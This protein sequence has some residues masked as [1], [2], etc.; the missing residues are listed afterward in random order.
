MFEVQVTLVINNLCPILLCKLFQ[1]SSGSQGWP[2]PPPLLPPKRS[3]W[4]KN[5][6]QPP[7]AVHHHHS[8]FISISPLLLIIPRCH[9]LVI[10]PHH[11]NSWLHI[12]LPNP[13]PVQETVTAD[14]LLTFY[15]VDM[16]L[17]PVVLMIGELHYVIEQID[18]VSNVSNCSIRFPI[19]STIADTV[20]VSI[21][22]LLPLFIAGSDCTTKVH[23]TGWGFGCVATSPHGYGGGQRQHN[24]LISYQKADGAVI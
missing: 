3:H 24:S 6:V 17:S 5:R 1:F 23:W 18:T 8:L 10:I 14:D 13:Q 9:P 11:H 4:Y 16:L 20:W 15:H 7:P 2:T 12:A 19:I 21:P 22:L